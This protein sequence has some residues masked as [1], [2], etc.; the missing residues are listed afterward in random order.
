VANFQN[1]SIT[2]GSASLITAQ[3]FTISLTVEDDAGN[4][5]ADLT[6]EN[7]LQ[8]PACLAQLTEDQRRELLGQDINQII[9]WIVGL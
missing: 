6:G 8:Y 3:N 2:P 4:V 1:F 7:A 9:S 5:I